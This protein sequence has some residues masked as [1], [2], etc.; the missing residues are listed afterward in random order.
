MLELKDD[1]FGTKP[2]NG[3][4][5]KDQTAKDLELVRWELNQELKRT[6]KRLEG[7]VEFLR[8]QIIKMTDHAGN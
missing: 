1:T 6:I 2:V 8:N 7:E 5:A 4:G 3:K